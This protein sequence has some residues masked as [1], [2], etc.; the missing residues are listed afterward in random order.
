[1]KIVSGPDVSIP[2][3]TLGFTKGKTAVIPCT[4]VTSMM[5]T[6]VRWTYNDIDLVMNNSKYTGA[7]LECHDL[8]INNWQLSDS[9]RY[10]CFATN[11]MGEGKSEE[12]MGKLIM[13]IKYIKII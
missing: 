10:R 5:V 11:I 3:N 2:T 6:S 13:I 12:I 1:M 7:T 8:I 9:G 4:V